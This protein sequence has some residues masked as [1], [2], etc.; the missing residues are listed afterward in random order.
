[1]RNPTSIPEM[2]D[3]S[4]YSMTAQFY[5]PDF[6]LAGRTLASMRERLQE[7]RIHGEYAF[8]MRARWV[9][10]ALPDRR[11][12]NA[13]AQWH[14][15]QIRNGVDLVHEG[16]LMRHCVHTYLQDC[17]RG[18]CSIWSLTQEGDAS[19]S[20]AATFEVRD[21]AIVQCRGF[22]NSTP[23]EEAIIIAKTWAAESGLS[24]AA[25]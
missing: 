22:A 16:K 11:Y 23:H 2:N 20:H 10:S 12:E 5:M 25:D 9:G 4:D 15:R 24:W 13:G 19:L 21:N 14:L 17:M 8:C 1:V 18:D 7:W 3:I 6:S